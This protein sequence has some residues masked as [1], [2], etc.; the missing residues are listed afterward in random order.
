MAYD[1]NLAD[2]VRE[3]LAELPNVEEK[4]MFGGV[5][6]MVNE[7]MCAG[8]MK[9]E[10]MCR[11]DPS[12]MAQLLEKPGCS[13]MDFTGRPMKSYVLV[14]KEAI[15]TKKQLDCWIDLCLEFNK[16]AK[17]S[18]KKKVSKKRI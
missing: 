8:V 10:L 4:E 15:K 13:Q 5:C 17:A 12:L 11:V 9:E 16:K 14:T 6:F 3:T 1:E 7:K 18:K 2:R